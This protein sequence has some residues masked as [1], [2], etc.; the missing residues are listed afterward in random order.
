MTPRGALGAI[1]RGY[2]RWI[3]PLLPPACR[4][5]PSCSV[6]AAEAVESHG[7]LKGAWLA[8][9]RLLRCNPWSRGGFDPVPPCEHPACE[10]A[11]RKRT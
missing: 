11:S 6:Y 9:Y 10:T 7:V 2:H 3:S 5:V 8:G 1:L 4:F